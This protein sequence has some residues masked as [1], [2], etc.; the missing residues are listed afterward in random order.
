MNQFQ[1]G[2]EVYT[3]GG[4]KCCFVGYFDKVQA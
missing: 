1:S 2:D 3:A 4:V